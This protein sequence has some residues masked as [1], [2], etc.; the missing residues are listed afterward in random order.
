MERTIRTIALT[1]SCPEHGEEQE[2]CSLGQSA[3]RQA[4]TFLLQQIR[5]IGSVPTFPQKNFSPAFF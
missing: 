1:R 4:K 5:C 3:F 2:K